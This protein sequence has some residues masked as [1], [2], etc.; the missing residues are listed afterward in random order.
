VQT[1]KLTSITGLGNGVLLFIMINFIKFHT[2]SVPHFK[3]VEITYF[4]LFSI[5]YLKYIINQLILN[6]R[7][8]AI[9]SHSNVLSVLRKI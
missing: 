5:F 3:S 7:G 8:F 2:S 6:N 9:D 4:K 1:G